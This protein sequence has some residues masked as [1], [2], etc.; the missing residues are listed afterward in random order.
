MTVCIAAICNGGSDII[1]ATD[2]MITS[3]GLSI[4]FEHPTKKMTRTIR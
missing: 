3:E 4:E 2:T 1:L